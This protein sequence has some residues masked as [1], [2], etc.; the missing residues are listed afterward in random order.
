MNRLSI[1][2]LALGVFLT[3]TSELVV[4]GILPVI[5]E[6]LQ[7]SIALAG[8]LITAYSLAFAIGTP[9]LVSL[10][11]RIGR[12]KV[13]LGSLAVF[14]AG[15]FVSYGSATVSLLMAS[16]I[17][18]GVSSGVYL[19]VTLGAVAK[20]VPAEKL[21]GAIGTIILGFSSAMVLGVPIGIA[22]AG[23]LSWQAIFLIL[24]LF[25][26]LVAFVIVR[27]LPET[28]GDAPVS[29]RQQ[30]KV[31]GSVVVVTGFL[32]TFFRESGNSILFTYLTPFMKDVLL[33]NAS[34]IGMIMLVFGIFGAIG[35]R[36]GGY[37]AD[38]W[39]ASRIITFGIIVQ[40]AVLALLPVYAGS[41]PI[42]LGLI[43][44]N[45][46]C[47][48]ATGPAIQTYFIQQAPH[49]SNLVLSLN[50]SIVHLGLAAGAGTGGAMANA[51][52]TV[53]YHPWMAS[54]VVAIGLSAAMVSF[55]LGKRRLVKLQER[56]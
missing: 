14:I 16:R 31:L 18:L 12:K 49:S 51:T 42:G 5:A 47:M 26:L 11:S 36:L 38:R 19:V 48:F 45:V 37:G 46:F 20:L 35:S 34:H 53:L 17:I 3:A 56:A 55:S 32:L 6:D 10:T 7:I 2:V 23:W 27:L 54:F 22:V 8:Q 30:F 28:E 50:T 21:G 41:L 9:I 1:Y 33:L 39:G 52:S 29:F 25:S 40:A 43:A 44:L 24:G 15:C 13:M 4:S